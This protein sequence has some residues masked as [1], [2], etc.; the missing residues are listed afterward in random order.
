MA[1]TPI[2]PRDRLQ[3][4]GDLA[5][6]TWRYWWLMSIFAVVGGALSLAFA[7]TRPKQFQSWTT[8]FYQ[9][10]IESQLL[11]P[12][13][14]EVAQRNIGDRYRELLL[15]RQQLLQI[16]NDPKLDPFPKDTD[17]E[18]KIDKLR[19]A[20]H[21]VARGAMA[22]RIEYTDS[23]AERAKNVTEKLTTLLQQKE[24]SLRNE[25]AHLTVDF[26]SKLK[27]EEQKELAKRERDLNEFLAKNP[28]FV[29]DTNAG[30]SEGAGI[31][32]EYKASNTPVA[33]RPMSIK[34][35][36]IQRIRARLNAP[37]DAPPVA[38]PTAPSPE[39]IAA[40]AT[41]KEAQREVTSAKKELDDALAKYTEQHPS[42]IKA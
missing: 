11:S 24:E 35:R 22:F 33:P 26:A 30:N 31:R 39:R 7:V 6:K 40:E 32:A 17:T 16:V 38:M 13:R 36:Q 21:F 19:Q 25:Q 1:L 28:A 34:E 15:A 29:A 5:R 18:I 3:R 20:V 4:L 12:N 14:E 8:L 23:D 27:D 9:E 37:P 2:T 10:R 41:V 42:A